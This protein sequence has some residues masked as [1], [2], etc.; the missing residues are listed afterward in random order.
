MHME[1]ILPVSAPPSQLIN[2]TCFSSFQWLCS[3]L[4]LLAMTQAQTSQKPHNPTKENRHENLEH[5]SNTGDNCPEA[6]A[7]AETL[8][9]YR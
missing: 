5:R 6:A 8:F 7:L 2:F 9:V 3:L 4:I 1:L